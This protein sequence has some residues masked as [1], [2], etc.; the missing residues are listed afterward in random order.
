MPT[1]R[2]NDIVETIG[3]EDAREQQV[4]G[5]AEDEWE[6]GRGNHP[7]VFTYAERWDGVLV[8]LAALASTGAGVASM[9][10]L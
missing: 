3:V 1:Y 10:M 8:A 4:E 7:R 2:S 9:H 6:T 5:E